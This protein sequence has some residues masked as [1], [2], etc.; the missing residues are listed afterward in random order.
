MCNATR[1]SW[2]GRRSR[3]VPGPI[4]VEQNPKMSSEAMKLE[5]IQWLSRLEDKGLLTA[6]LQF[7]K[8]SEARDW[9]DGLSPDQR[10]AIAQ[11][12]ADIKAG[13]TIAAEQ[14]WAKYGRTAQD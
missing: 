3:P 14:L 8:T 13:R 7:K 12:E 9:Y 4:F 11:G 10:E 6:L 1:C 2:S 5:L